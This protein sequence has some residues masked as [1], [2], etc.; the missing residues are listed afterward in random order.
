MSNKNSKVL[1]IADKVGY[2]KCWDDMEKLGGRYLDNLEL[3]YCQARNAEVVG[4]AIEDIP[5]KVFGFSKD[6]TLEYVFKAVMDQAWEDAETRAL[7][8]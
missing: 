3:H 7:D 5:S 1:A 8:W 4:V 2:W 6:D